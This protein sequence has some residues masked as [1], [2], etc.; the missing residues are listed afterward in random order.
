MRSLTFP[1]LVR[2]INKFEDSGEIPL[3]ILVEDKCSKSKI[4]SVDLDE[5]GDLILELGDYSLVDFMSL[6]DVK[7]DIEFYTH[8]IPE[9]KEDGT[10][11]LVYTDSESKSLNIE[12]A[13]KD[14]SGNVLLQTW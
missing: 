4:I 3:G 6:E 13:V 7:A 5:Y 11:R 10:I 12:A 2:A 9:D 8:S 14:S 1:E